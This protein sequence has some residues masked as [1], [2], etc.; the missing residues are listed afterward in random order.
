MAHENRTRGYRSI[1]V[2]ASR[3][4]ARSTNRTP[5]GQSWFVMAMAPPLRSP[6]LPVAGRTPPESAQRAGRPAAPPESLQGSPQLG[7]DQ[8]ARELAGVNDR[9][10]EASQAP[11]PEPPDTEHPQGGAF[12]GVLTNRPDEIGI[13]TDP[14]VPDLRAQL[15]ISPA[16]AMA[17][18][19]LWFV[20]ECRL[21]LQGAKEDLEVT[22]AVGAGANVQCRIETADA[23]EE[24]PPERRSLP[25]RTSLRAELLSD[26]LAA[27]AS[28]IPAFDAPA[29]AAVGLEQGLGL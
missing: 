1:P 19:C 28:E 20:D 24:R 12:V 10:G 13:E 6:D 14:V 16:M 22:A 25:C 27:R 5:I 23:V 26:R 2:I 7:E 3:P 15:G 29:E 8:I 21:V 9:A 17:D 18:D 11:R 4:A